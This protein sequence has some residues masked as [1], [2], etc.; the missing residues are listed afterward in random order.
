MSNIWYKNSQ[1]L[2]RLK[3]V[4]TLLLPKRFSMNWITPHWRETEERKEW[5]IKKTDR[6]RVWFTLCGQL[7]GNTVCWHCKEQ[8]SG[9]STQIQETGAGTY[10]GV[11]VPH[12]AMVTTKPTDDVRYSL[13][14][15]NTV[16]ETWLSSC[17]GK[18]TQSTYRP[19]LFPWFT[20]PLSVQLSNSASWRTGST[21]HFYAPFEA[22]CVNLCGLFEAPLICTIN[23]SKP[24][25]WEKAKART[26]ELYH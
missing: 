17:L 1:A 5:K 6:K 13:I 12:V 25:M 18:S 9:L 16:T 11:T 10:S 23:S 8:T 4:S 20:V 15:T 24:L 19:V 3:W 7:C 14:V 2:G 26:L 22:T 21:Q